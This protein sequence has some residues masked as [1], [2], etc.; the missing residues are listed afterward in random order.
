LEI[1]INEVYLRNLLKDRKSTKTSLFS[2]RLGY[3]SNDSGSP[4]TAYGRRH[5]LYAINNRG[6]NINISYY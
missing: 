6:V 2:L 4:I 1:I 5:D 3:I